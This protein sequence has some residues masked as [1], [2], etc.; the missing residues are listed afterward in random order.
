M[1]EFVGGGGGGGGGRVLKD[2]W[3]MCNTLHC[4]G[5]IVLE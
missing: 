4:I 1:D 2:E 5:K 3:F